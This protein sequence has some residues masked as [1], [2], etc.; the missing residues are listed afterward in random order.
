MKRNS[1]GTLQIGIILLVIATAA[2]HLSLGIPN[3]LVMFILNGI[4]YLILVTA[5]Y[6]PQLQRYRRLIR[7]ALIAFA[8]VTIVGWIAIGARTTIGYLDK[9]IEVVLIIL[10]MIE[11]RQDRS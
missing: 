2:I 3:F 1:I 9:V 11:M 6:L 5:L 10:L 4:G 8:A 7:W